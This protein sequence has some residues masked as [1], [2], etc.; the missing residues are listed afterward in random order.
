MYCEDLPAGKWNGNLRIGFYWISFLK[1]SDFDMTWRRLE[2]FFCARILFVRFHS[3]LVQILFCCVLD[4]VYTS[5]TH[6]EIYL[7]QHVD[8]MTRF[9]IL[10]S[11]TVWAWSFN[12]NNLK[13]KQISKE[14]R[15]V[16]KR[17]VAG[18]CGLW[19]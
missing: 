13:A 6:L 3:S 9:S 4:I 7:I 12:P 2:D 8:N 11:D 10:V 14:Q 19:N 5:Y 15:S 16:M 1:K 18:A 17:Y